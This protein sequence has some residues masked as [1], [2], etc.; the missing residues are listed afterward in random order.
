MDVLSSH[1]PCYARKSNP[2]LL[3]LDRLLR[4]IQRSQKGRL[5]PLDL[6]QPDAHPDETRF[7]AEIVGPIELEVVRQKGVRAGQSKVGTQT[8]SLVAF[9]RV[10]ERLGGLLSGKR[11]GK[12]TPVTTLA[13]GGESLGDPIVFRGDIS[14]VIHPFEYAIRRTGSVHLGLAD[15]QLGQ[16]VSVV[17]DYRDSMTEVSRISFHVNGV[18]G[19]IVVLVPVLLGGL[20]VGVKLGVRRQHQAAE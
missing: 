8:R 13:G 15:E 11:Q 4:S 16:V 1:P 9:E 10:E 17:V 3:G 14:R 19:E 5:E 18:F 20:E 2:H 6:L 12:Q 7:H